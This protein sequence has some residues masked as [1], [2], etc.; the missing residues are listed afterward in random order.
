MRPIQFGIQLQPRHTTWPA[1]LEA[2]RAVEDLD[3][4]SVWNFDHLLAPAGDPAGA[5]FETMTTLA[6]MA[7]VTHRIGVG[8]LV[9]GVLYRDPAT[10]AK[11]AAMVD[12][13]SGGRLRFALGASWA[14]R[15]FRAYGLPFPAVG[16]RLSRLE[17]AVDIVTALWTQPRVTYHG[18]FYTIDDAPCEP[19]PLQRPYPPIMIG[20]TGRR[21]LR[22]AARKAAA[23]NGIGSPEEIAVAVDSLRAS[24]AAIERDPAEIGLTVHAQLVIGTTHEAAQAK[25]RSLTDG[26]GMDLAAEQAA[27]L[28]GTPEEICEKIRRYGALGISGFIMGAGA[29]FDLEGLEQFA[30][31]VAPQF[32]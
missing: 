29:P 25:A 31:Q 32:R 7:S 1:Y 12:H 8:T 24:C 23:W 22:L 18:A 16:E 4:E 14:E 3:Y 5:C 20:G 2:V 15:E 6:A 26:L 27:W 10:L 19:K 13:V 9:N 17:E 11:S 28:V 21:T 30:A